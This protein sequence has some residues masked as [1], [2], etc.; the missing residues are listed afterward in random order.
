MITWVDLDD[1]KIPC[2]SPT[3]KQYGYRM[4]TTNDKKQKP[5]YHCMESV[6]TSCLIWIHPEKIGMKQCEMM[7]DAITA[8]CPQGNAALRANLTFL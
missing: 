3:W 4:I 6:S 5:V 1:E 8:L 2:C 7:K